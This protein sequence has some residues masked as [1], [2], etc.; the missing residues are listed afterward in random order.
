MKS[1]CDGSRP[2]CGTCRRKGT[3]DSVILVFGFP[4]LSN[5]SLPGVGC[6]YR[7]KGQPGIRPGYGKAVEHR[8]S[9][10]EASIERISQSVEE[11]LNPRPEKAT[12]YP[13]MQTS[14]SSEARVTNDGT[15]QP[16]QVP[17]QLPVPGLEPSSPMME[18]NLP[19]SISTLHSTDR[20]LPPVEIVKELVDL[21]FELVYPWAPLFSKPDF[22]TSMFQPERQ[23][24]LHGI[25]V[26]S[27]RL[28]TKQEPL[29][30]QR[31]AYVKVSREEVFLKTIDAY[32]LISTQALA[33]LAVDAIGQGPG[34]RTLNIFAMLTTAAEQLGLSR[35]V[36]GP[37][38]TPPDAEIRT[39]LIRDEGMDKDLDLTDIQEEEKQRLFV[40]IYNL[41]RFSCVFH[42][43]PGD[44]RTNNIRLVSSASGGSWNQ[45]VSSEWFQLV[46]PIKSFSI[47]HLPHLWPQYI[48]VLIFLD[49]S[50]RL[51]LQPVLLS[52]AT[53]C[54]EWQRNFRRLE[55]N[56]T[57]WF[58]SLPRN[59]Q[60]APTSFNPLW[61]MLCATFYLYSPLPQHSMPFLTNMHLVQYP[62]QNVYCCSI[63]IGKLALSETVYLGTSSSSPVNWRDGIFSSIPSVTRA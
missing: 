24:L 54:Q 37:R 7:E 57:A 41:D 56:L 48:D 25:V 31:E 44:Y 45:P 15:T 42:G 29:V 53:Y 63:S 61:T 47:H 30:E 59:I 58:D 62:N 19:G 1:K 12:A 46:S 32:S 27:F 51:L 8:L 60:E 2:K 39:P 33:L 23:L 3:A 43:Q 5:L 49:R 52:F 16:W 11:A 34:P 10:L 22:I 20:R 17:Q 6:I 14:T 18:T 35:S 36:T 9:L 28:W 38:L 4:P 13:P 55:S 21:F 40:V 26:V 50:N